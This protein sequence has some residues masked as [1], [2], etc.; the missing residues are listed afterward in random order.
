MRKTLGNAIKWTFKNWVV[1]IPGWMLAL[2]SK[3]D[4][5]FYSVAIIYSFMMAKILNEE[6]KIKYGK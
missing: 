2:I 3:D 4:M 5:Q 1:F 6:W